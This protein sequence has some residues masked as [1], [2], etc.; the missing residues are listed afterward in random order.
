MVQQAKAPVILI[1]E[2]RDR[3]KARV[4]LQLGLDQHG[5]RAGVKRV[6]RREPRPQPCSYLPVVVHAARSGEGVEEGRG[7]GLNLAD[8]DQE[9]RNTA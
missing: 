2:L 9:Q 4:V 5:Q 3:Q 8:L 6:I 1:A 7:T